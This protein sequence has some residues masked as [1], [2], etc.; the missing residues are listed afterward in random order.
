MTTR[1][2]RHLVPDSPLHRQLET[3]LRENCGRADTTAICQEVLLLSNMDPS[4][5]GAL[6]QTLIE[7]DA[8]LR[9]VDGRVELVE[10]SAPEVWEACR[11]FTV[12][13]VEAANGSGPTRIIEIGVCVVE[14]GR[15]VREWSSLVNPGRSIPFWIRQLTGITDSTVRTAPTFEELLPR[16][17]EDLEGAILVGHHARFDVGCLNTEVNRLL[18]KRLAN[19]YLCTAELARRFLPGSDNYRLQTL[20]EWLRLTHECPHRAGSDAR[21]TAELFCHL[22]KKPHIPWSDY[23]RPR[24]VPI[25]QKKTETNPAADS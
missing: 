19:F 24:W 16:V 5:A 13:D 1:G 20:S 8:R 25:P 7:E 17:L 6:V 9:M 2:Y 18:G 15:L 21:A 22:L 3:L 14:D 23:L 12:V 11:R 4:M 10:P